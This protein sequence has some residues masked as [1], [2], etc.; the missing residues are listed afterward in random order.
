MTVIATRI[1]PVADRQLSNH[2]S[3]ALTVRNTLTMASRG[4]LKI[5][6]TPE[7]LIDEMA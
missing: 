4:I 3:R 2:S 1:V 5:R 7:Q 6:R